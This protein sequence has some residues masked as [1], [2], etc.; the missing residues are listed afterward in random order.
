LLLAQPEFFVPLLQ[1]FPPPDPSL[2][3]ARC[4]ILL[5]LRAHALGLGA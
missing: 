3:L 5:L 2:V 4:P 1:T